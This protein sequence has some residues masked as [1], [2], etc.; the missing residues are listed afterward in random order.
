M[1][2]PNFNTI[3]PL[4]ANIPETAVIQKVHSDDDRLPNGEHDKAVKAFL[5]SDG[6]AS[7]IGKDLVFVE[8]IPQ[9][10]SE[11]IDNGT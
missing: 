3:D 11:I 5:V 6:I 7:G 9:F 8:K 2:N 4:S 1:N 10:I